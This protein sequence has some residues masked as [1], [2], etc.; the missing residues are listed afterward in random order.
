MRRDYFGPEVAA[1]YDDSLE[2]DRVADTTTPAV[3][4]LADLAGGAPALEFGIGTGRVALPLAARGVPVSGIDLS[5]A[6][7]ERLRR[8]P[9]GDQVEVVIGD[10][11]CSQVPGDFSLVYVVFNTI[12]NLTSQ[13]DQ[14]GCFRNAARHLRP[15]GRFVVELAVPDL[16]R[17]P[18]GET[19]GRSPSRRAISAS[20]S[21]TWPA[22]A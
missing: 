12:G 9:G 18:T 13:A 1:T 22:R 14:V 6:M 2:T 8:K 17:L 10:F 19:V 3:E 15:G 16:Q 5:R 4:L 7:V 11:A 21:T 20:T